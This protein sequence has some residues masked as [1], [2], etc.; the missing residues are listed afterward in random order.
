[1]AAL[2]AGFSEE[3]GMAGRP[4]L[5]TAIAWSA[6]RAYASDPAFVL[7][8]KLAVLLVVTWAVLVLML[9]A[10][11]SPPGVAESGLPD[12]VHGDRIWSVCPAEPPTALQQ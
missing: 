10:A 12:C 5:I 3:A 4:R 6:G 11:P 8:F 7:G 9:L 2:G 1:M